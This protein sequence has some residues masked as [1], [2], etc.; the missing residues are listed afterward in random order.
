MKEEYPVYRRVAKINMEWFRKYPVCPMVVGVSGARNLRCGDGE[1]SKLIT[2]REC[3]RD[4]REIDLGCAAHP[5][6]T[7]PHYHD[8]K[9]DYEIAKVLDEIDK[10]LLGPC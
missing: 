6:H 8:Y 1:F 10:A 2:L 9:R 3:H 4:G 7:Q 5:W